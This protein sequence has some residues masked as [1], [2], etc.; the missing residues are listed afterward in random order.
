MRSFEKRK[1][2]RKLSP[3]KK[4]FFQAKLH[5]NKPGDKFEQEADSIAKK[6]TRTGQKDHDLFFKP[7]I[8]QAS[9]IDNFSHDNWTVSVICQRIQ[10]N[11]QADTGHG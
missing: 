10:R 6:V 2:K 11:Y 8:S 3:I 1:D 5:V 7:Q 4:G 9:E